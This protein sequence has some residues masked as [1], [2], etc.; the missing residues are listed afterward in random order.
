MTIPAV[1]AFKR[2]LFR[3]RGPESAPIVL[4]QRRIFVLPTRMGLFYPALLLVMLLGAINYTLSL[5]F[6]LTFMLTGLG[7]VT[8]L[9]TFRNLL[10]L[11]ISPSRTQAVFAGETAHFGLSLKNIRSEDRYAIVLSIKNNARV[12]VDVPAQ[13]ASTIH[14]PFLTT[15]RGWIRPDRIT[16][17]TRYPIGLVR[18][19]SYAEPD[20]HCLVYPAPEVDAPSL[21][22]M[23]TGESGGLR[24][25]IG[26]EDFAGI[27]GHR[28]TDPPQHIAWKAVSRQG[29]VD[30]FYDRDNKGDS[31][32]PAGSNSAP[33]LT[34]QFAGA[35]AASLWLEWKN[36][37]ST[38]DTE[39]RL[40]RLTSWLIEA[41]AA[42]L[43]F[44]LRLPNKE[45]AP[46]Q[47]EQHL[48]ACLEVLALY[49]EKT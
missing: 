14:I 41:N 42:K 11:E 7:V 10:R 1:T 39:A 26:S 20:M 46:A 12:S 2:W 19:W 13:S 49:G 29:D 24:S 32:S 23:G 27:R 9:H 30:D 38:L 28:P 21:V 43:S 16:V 15:R 31:S 44:G 3:L 6:V 37:P 25:G 18:A 40:S 47:G 34:K 45:L 48:H 22:L 4:V 17:E 36:L 5:G 8:M 33:L 35:S